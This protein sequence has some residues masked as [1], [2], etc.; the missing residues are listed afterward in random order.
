MPVQVREKFDRL[1]AVKALAVIDADGHP[2]CFAG[3]PL[4][5]AGNAHLL[6]GGATARALAALPPA[7]TSLPPC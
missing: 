2:D 6:F 5:T 3:M 7:R 4:T 1:K